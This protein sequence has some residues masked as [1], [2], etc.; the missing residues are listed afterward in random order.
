[1]DI[2]GTLGTGI[3]APIVQSLAPLQNGPLTPPLGGMQNTLILQPSLGID[4][5]TRG[6]PV[7]GAFKN[8]AVA[9]STAADVVKASLLDVVTTAPPPLAVGATS[10][11]ANSDGTTNQFVAS[12]PMTSSMAGNLETP[13]QRLARLLSDPNGTSNPLSQWQ[14]SEQLQNRSA[15]SAQGTTSQGAAALQSGQSQTVLTQDEAGRSAEVTGQGECPET[16]PR[17]QSREA[18]QGEGSSSSSSAPSDDEGQEGSATSAQGTTSQGAAALQSGQSQTVL[19]QEEARQGEELFSS[20]SA[21][22]DDEGQANAASVRQKISNAGSS[23]G[24]GGRQLPF[25]QGNAKREAEALRNGKMLESLENLEDEFAEE[26]IRK[27]TEQSALENPYDPFQNSRLVPLARKGMGQCFA[28]LESLES[29]GDEDIDDVFADNVSQTNPQRRFGSAGALAPLVWMGMEQD[30]AIDDESFTGAERAADPLNSNNQNT[31]RTAAASARDAAGVPDQAS[32]PTLAPFA[33]K[34]LEPASVALGKEEIVKEIVVEEV[35]N[36]EKKAAA[37]ALDVSMT[38]GSSSASGLKAAQMAFQGMLN[39]EV[40]MEFDARRPEAVSE[41]G[42]VA[43]KQE[44]P[45]E[46]SMLESAAELMAFINQSRPQDI[47]GP[48][49]GGEPGFG[50][51]GRA[52][53]RRGDGEDSNDQQRRERRNRVW[54]ALAESRA[55]RECD[56]KAKSEAE[57]ADEKTQRK[58]PNRTPPKKPLNKLP[59]TP[60]APP[61]Y[62]RL[63]KAW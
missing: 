53:G 45:N 46:K 44:L 29:L 41:Q 52:R 59:L 11:P 62:A 50:L 58:K 2:Q 37:S 35:M 12:D 40:S 42:W 27:R 63:P 1:M 6:V 28:G 5:I 56:E 3:S 19:T 57:A 26:P 34:G 25:L 36:E 39:R 32:D 21:P 18:G 22:S 33:R 8:S 48:Y 7:G 31:W 47:G 13:G 16:V 49:Y 55:Q 38:S 30:E 61:R 60:K 43:G 17:V 14:V 9:D 4:L 10:S 23:V 15:A 20:S 54:A 24:K 51:R